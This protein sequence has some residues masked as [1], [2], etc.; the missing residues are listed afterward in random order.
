[1]SIRI[2]EHDRAGLC[3]DRLDLTHAV[4]LL[5]GRRQ[6]MLADAVLSVSGNRRDRREPGLDTI[7]ESS[8]A[9]PSRES[10]ASALG[11]TS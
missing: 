3:A 7:A 1:M 11:S 6:L 5:R 4:I 9:Y 2:C 8:M 10:R